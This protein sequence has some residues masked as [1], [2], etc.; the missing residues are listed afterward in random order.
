MPRK[1]VLEK[2]EEKEE[3]MS[4]TQETKQAEEINV[5][6]KEEEPIK[7]SV[8]SLYEYFKNIINTTIPILKWVYFISKIYILWITLHY[9]SCQLYIQYCV[10]TGIMGYMISPFLV[11][12][13]HCKALR[14]AFYTGGNVIDNM[15][16]YLGVWFSSQLLNI[17]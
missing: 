4:N 10:P 16:N 1:K 7:E 3:K 17:T 13:P 14:W 9:L 8:N 6:E 5:V 2:Q 11:S 15:W 12:S